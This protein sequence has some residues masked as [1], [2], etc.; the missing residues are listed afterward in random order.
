MELLWLAAAERDLMELYDRAEAHGGGTALLE[1]IGQSTGNLRAFP[2]IAPVFAG[3][4]RRLVLVKLSLGVFYAVEGRRVLILRVLD[5][6]Q[7][8]GTIRRRLGLD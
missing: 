8:P 7:H 3:S 2:L 4:I 1:R 6:R 5:L